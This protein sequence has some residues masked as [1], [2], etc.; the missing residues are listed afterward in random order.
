MAA[1]SFY[2]ILEKIGVPQLPMSAHL[3][4]Q[5]GTNYSES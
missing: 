1:L 2:T 3:D 5:Y 4:F